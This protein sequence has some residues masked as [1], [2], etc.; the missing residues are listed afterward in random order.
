[1]DR[2]ENNASGSDGPAAVGTSWW[3]S[4]RG[5][6]AL[7][8]TAV[9]LLV[10]GYVA[11]GFLW[12]PVAVERGLTR[13][14]ATAMQSALTIGEVHVDPFRMV[15]V[16]DDVRLSAADAHETL[17]VHR[18]EYRLRVLSLLGARPVLDRLVLAQPQMMLGVDRPA[19][20]AEGGQLP[21]RMLAALLDA[22]PFRIERL[23]LID[24]ELQVRRHTGGDEHVGV[25]AGISLTARSIDSGDAAVPAQYLLEIEETPGG[26]LTLE[27][28]ARVRSAT[29]GQPALEVLSGH[30]AAQALR[31]QVSPGLVFR[32]PDTGIEDFAATLS[33]PDGSIEAVARLRIHEALLRDE[34]GVGLALSQLE[35]AL[36][37][38]R[39]AHGGVELQ[40][41]GDSA[42]AGR[43]SLA[44]SYKTAGA[45]ATTKLTL[46]D[47]A[48]EP[49]SLM[50][51][52]VVGRRVSAGLATI[53][54]HS[55][56]IE[57]G[58]EPTVTLEVLAA[59]L[60]LAPEPQL[61]AA[62][63]GVDA[64][65]FIA[66]LEDPRGEIRFTVPVPMRPAVSASA[67]L[68]LALRSYA[69]ATVAAP[70]AALG[71]ALEMPGPPPMTVEF[72][73]GAAALTPAATE[74]LDELAA[75]LLLRPRLGVAVPAR[76]DPQLDRDALARQQVELHVT[77]ATART[78]FRARPQ[79]V[80][81]A[82]AR[83]QNV[84]D[85]FAGERLPADVLA[86]IAAQH[87]R[88]GEPQA[89]APYYREVFAALVERERIE[90]SALERI[91][92][93][94]A[95][96]I[97]DAL[98]G[99]GLPSASV[100]VGEDVTSGSSDAEQAKVPVQLRLRAHSAQQQPGRQ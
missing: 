77:L 30:G 86:A 55:A 69:L 1:M 48:A 87:E 65:L 67:A 20:S 21:L 47:V 83:A 59:N 31:L 74:T 10:A 82:S 80:D 92:R 27:G 8:V 24:G 35:G 3:R 58:A 63:A 7:L 39:S 72:E 60:A 57:F 78:A 40:L 19:G 42:L 32:A 70:A 29:T 5:R 15:V 71:R 33:L 79:P 88:S 11:M 94:R 91:G 61:G 41:Q 22:E 9:L 49:L 68:T 44:S 53:S 98:T 97:A 50:L 25:Y 17:T 89:R 75:A 99:L 36:D 95:R 90:R 37:V 43:F 51:E 54:L 6:V 28:A 56:G 26:R 23:Q 45:A 64:E 84:L 100:E 81:F 85:E 76:I 73:P 52:R 14:A 12:A 16:L 38:G 46:H 34:D 18:V 2:N 4:A 66:L 93:Y 96:S 62:D 13:T